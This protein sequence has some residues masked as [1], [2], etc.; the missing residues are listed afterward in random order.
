MNQL[1]SKKVLVVGGSSG[2]GAATA[3]AFAELGADVL[4]A[5]RDAAKLAA[6][7][8]GIGKSVST[9]V[10]DSTDTDA[11]EAFFAN[12]GPF[13]HVVISA[14]QTRGGPIRQLELADAY[15]AMDS[16]F[17]G[18]YRVARAVKI[19]DGGSLTLVSGFLSVRPSKT[20]VLQGAINAAL[21]ALARG[22]ALEL[23]PVRVNT[24]SPG[25]I[26]TPLWSKLTEDDRQSMYEGAAARLPA[27]RVGQP[28]DVANAVVYLAST[29]FA[30][31]STVLVDGGGAIA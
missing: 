26:A 31:G 15:A 29:P 4:I 6:T 28:E 1:T 3:K 27:R 16:K 24:V 30:T 10:L 22:L 23:S 7:A 11:V 17:W 13:D 18:A 8:T 12:A 2:I 5:S 25:L 9:A 14:A 19:T 21:E 20:S